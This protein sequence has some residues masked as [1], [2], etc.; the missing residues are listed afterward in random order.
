MTTTLKLRLKREEIEGQRNKAFGLPFLP[1]FSTNLFASSLFFLPTV[2]LLSGPAYIN[3]TNKSHSK[4][5]C[6]EKEAMPMA[7][8]RQSK[9]AGKR[10]KGL[11]R[12]GLGLDFGQEKGHH[13]TGQ[14]RDKHKSRLDNTH[15]PR[16]T[17]RTRA[18][19]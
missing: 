7:K 5:Q 15:T 13:R 8:A 4:C 3:T 14:G 17:N 16:R 18:E 6:K 11:R 19:K 9:G 12:T 10:R 1:L 2:G